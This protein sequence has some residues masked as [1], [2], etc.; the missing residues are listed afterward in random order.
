MNHGSQLHHP[1]PPPPPTAHPSQV[2]GQSPHYARGRQ[3][4]GTFGI[5]LADTSD[6]HHSYANAPP[7]PTS[8]AKPLTPERPNRFFRTR[9]R[10]YLCLCFLLFLLLLIILIPLIILVIVPAVAQSA[11]NGSKMSI[12][13]AHI[14]SPKEDSFV[15]RMSGLVTDTGPF[16]AEIEMA[17]PIQV[18]SDGVLLGEMM[19][20]P[21]SSK[22]GVGAKL[23]SSPTFRVTNK[24]GFGDFSGRML[25]TESFTWTLDGEVNIHAMG[26]TLTGIRLQKD[27]TMKGM[28][29][30]PGVKILAFDLPS[31]H[32]DGGITLSITSSLVNP[33]PI[34]M[35]VGDMAFDITYR[36]M[37]I[38]E[39]EATSVNLLPGVNEI[40]MQ[41][42]MIPQSSS[43]GLDVVS[44]MFTRY[45]AGETS[46]MSCIGTRTRPNSLSPP[47]SWLQK[48]FAGMKLDVP[49]PGA[50]NLKL[51]Q[52]VEIGSMDM[53]F[54]PN[55]AYSPSA[56]SSAVYASFKMPFAFPLEMR[57]VEQD[58][59]ILD[60]GSELIHMTTPWSPASGSSA[61]GIMTTGFDNAA[62]EVLKGQEALFD[63][64]VYDLNMDAS[65]SFTMR[66][67]ANAVAS[68]AVGDVTIRGIKF[69]DTVSLLGLK[70]LNSEPITVNSMKLTGGTPDYLI[71][72]MVVGMIN[73][74]NVGI[75]V[76]HVEMDAYYAG[77]RMGRVIIPNMVLKPGMNSVVSRMHYAPQGSSAIGAG[78]DLLSK[79]V[80]SQDS[81]M[82]VAGTSD[83]T[84]IQSLRPALQAI[85]FTTVVPGLRNQPLIKQAYFSINLGTVF[86]RKAKAA[87]DAYN[88]LDADIEFIGMESVMYYKGKQVGV[89]SQDLRSNPMRIP[90]KGV[91]HSP[92]WPVK[93]KLNFTAIKL[94]L[95]A[96]KGGLRLEITSV[97]T[98]SVGGYE[99][100]LDYSQSGVRTVLGK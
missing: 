92:R 44:D 21:I 62:M 33:S 5:R 97:I 16:D 51:I 59:S 22:A 19:M 42:R 8:P 89:I 77:H 7:P 50:K 67:Q 37:K 58:I 24:D 80:M 3:E 99:M 2:M 34:G 85:R 100:V 40:Q 69:E 95:S 28:N 43:E 11:I 71:I 6:P 96:I 61:E 12:T 53:T 23:E 20:D 52:K 79:Y 82:G 15:M 93:I 31:N 72:D 36:D 17:T 65:K 4:S 81:V 66:G 29:N 73:P 86:T 57:Q 75:S 54:T 94:L 88:P 14:T 49:F 1:S 76:G 30:F 98:T 45:M 83:S 41:G 63:R 78:R 13:S 38:G 74:S 91:V 87:I 18:Y 60:G 27:I 64:F 25:R 46:P 84:A 47:L 9:K 70:G 55:T 10:M 26:M 68:T 56:S 35:E 90:A 32:P 39:A 48:G